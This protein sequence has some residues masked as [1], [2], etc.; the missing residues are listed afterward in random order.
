MLALAPNGAP[1]Y[2][3]GGA[4][5]EFGPAA[6]GAA[7][8]SFVFGQAVLASPPP[9]SLVPAEASSLPKP[10]IIEEFRRSEAALPRPI[11]RPAS[12]SRPV[13]MG[14]VTPVVRRRRAGVGYLAGRMWWLRV[15]AAGV[16]SGLGLWQIALF[17]TLLALVVLGLLYAFEDQLDINQGP[18]FSESGDGRRAGMRPMP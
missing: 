5:Y 4:V 3:G 6:G 15:C 1:R 8:G 7:A 2:G 9:A 10:G 12:V 18:D 14:G 11:A 13:A 17:A 16:A